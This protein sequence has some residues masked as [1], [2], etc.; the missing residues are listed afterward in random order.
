[1]TA[2]AKKNNMR[3][4]SVVMGAETS[5]K[6]SSDTT[7]LLNYGFNTYKTHVVLTTK[8]SLGVKRVENGVVE[9]ADIVLTKDY[10]KLLK[11]TDAKPNYSFNVSVDSLVAPLKK[12]DI[13]GKVSVVDENGN[14]IDTLD[15]TIK[16]DIP[17]ASWWQ[18]F[19][20]NLKH[21]T[22]GQILIK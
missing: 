1:M 11:Q 14:V 4:I 5:D 7:S 22:A 8:D 20:K 17:K 6:R 18:A 10:V 13:V 16:E 19:L 12:G 3:L 15:V 2:T 21:L 9:Q